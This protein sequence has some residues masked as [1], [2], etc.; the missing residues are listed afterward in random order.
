MKKILFAALLVLPVVAL[1]QPVFSDNFADGDRN[2]WFSSSTTGTLTVV[3]GAMNQTTGTAG[4]S[5]MTYFPSTTLSVGE[6]LTLSFTMQMVGP[7]GANFNINTGNN[8]QL[9]FGLFNSDNAVKVAAD[10]YGSSTPYNFG[11]QGGYASVASLLQGSTN[12]DTTPAGWTIRERTAA[13]A[14]T[15]LISTT[16]PYSTLGD[17]ELHAASFALDTLYAATMIITRT[18]LGVDIFAK[19]TGGSLGATYEIIR[20]D[21]EIPVITFDMLAIHLNSN[22]AAGFT[23]DDVIV[24]RGMAPIPEPSTYA[25]IAG[26]LSLMGVMVWR[27]RRQA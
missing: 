9:R 15:A 8:N 2:G 24:S 16:S 12:S 20:S 19:Y 17:T 11:S 13:T 10:N 18:N 5:A 21:N 6:T 1:A 4:R 14:S 3:N 27:R 22:I 23:V 25:A 26:A 7:A